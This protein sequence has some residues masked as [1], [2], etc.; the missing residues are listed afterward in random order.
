MPRSA[1]A[2]TVA[3]ALL[4]LGGILAACSASREP[5]ATAAADPADAAPSQCDAG[6][7]QRWIGEDLSGYVERQA[8]AESGAQE[9]RVL[10]P[11]D[12]ATMDF[13]PRRLN[14]HVDPGGVIIKLACG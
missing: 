12:A 8:A 10:K 11:G 2:I 6:K 13:N 4:A 14:I 3:L 9:T 7:V 1:S 5:Q